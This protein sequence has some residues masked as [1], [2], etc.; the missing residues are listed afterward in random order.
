VRLICG[1]YKN[2]YNIIKVSYK[3][4]ASVSLL[5]RSHCFKTANIKILSV[6]ATH[7]SYHHIYVFF[8]EKRMVYKVNGIK[9]L[10]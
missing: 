4:L 8:C 7:R 10:G 2:N 1:Y 5:R 9:N 3:K 6:N